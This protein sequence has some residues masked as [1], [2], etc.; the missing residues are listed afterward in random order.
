M[1]KQTGLSSVTRHGVFLLMLFLA[2]GAANAQS[3]EELTQKGRD[4][5]GKGDYAAALEYFN[6][7]RAQQPDDA[8]NS[9]LTFYSAV[10]QQQAAVEASPRRK[11]RMLRTAAR[12]YEDYLDDR[13]DSAAL[14]NL[15]KVYEELGNPELA[16]QSYR[17]AIATGD[18]KSA[19][20]L[21]NYAE[22]LDSAGNSEEASAIYY[23]MLREQPLSTRQQSEIGAR[24]AEIGLD[25]YVRFLWELTEVGSA[26]YA[27]D[28]S[29]KTLLSERD[30][31]TGLRNE[32]LAILAVS[33]AQQPYQSGSAQD[34][35]F[36][37]NLNEFAWS[38]DGNDGAQQ[39]LLLQHAASVIQTIAR[40]GYR[41]ETDQS[42]L[43]DAR[44]QLDPELY[45]WWQSEGRPDIDPP[46]GVW[47]SD[48]LRQLIRSHGDRVRQATRLSVESG[49]PSETISSLAEDFYALSANLQDWEVDPLA[50]RELVR[51]KIQA[52]DLPS[53]KEILATYEEKLFEGKG[54]AIRNQQLEKTFEFHKTLG[55]IY[56]QLSIWGDSSSARSAVFQ[57]EH[58]R[59]KSLQIEEQTDGRV[60]EAYQFTPEM[61]DMLDRAYQ[62]EGQPAKGVKLRLD[63]ARRY[64]TK[65]DETA[66][67]EVLKPVES[68]S[69]PVEFQKYRIDQDELTIRRDLEAAEI[70]KARPTVR[71]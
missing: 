25:S 21:R 36:R 11:A 8:L 55:E 14:N 59:K 10:T 49:L 5:L 65:G 2:M 67:R 32:L 35:L 68:D 61:V 71:Q 50:V 22:Y 15:A 30:A 70:E 44:S 64:E 57:L 9:K 31:Q 52:D 42:A 3:S 40:L 4:A 19:L 23:S 24:F 41:N 13:Q 17:R 28:Q 38:G 6:A 16:A 60:P 43:A 45:S 47:P 39:L 46:R 18:E 27:A 37:S 48:G 53:V 34:E 1:K 26:R 12:L 63:E 33:L 29:I 51:L 54:G 69:L 58:A 56:T 20:Y 62:A 7:A 66:V